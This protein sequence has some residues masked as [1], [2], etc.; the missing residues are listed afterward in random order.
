MCPVACYVKLQNIDLIVQF[1]FLYFL[2][3]ISLVFDFIS[4]IM[5]NGQF[6]TVIQTKI[7]LTIK[8]KYN[9]MLRNGNSVKEWNKRNG[10]NIFFFWK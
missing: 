7:A 6:Y 2:I 9:V 10:M 5:R 3:K 1:S 8:S 4:S